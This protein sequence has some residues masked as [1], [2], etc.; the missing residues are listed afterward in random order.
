MTVEEAAEAFELSHPGSSN[1]LMECPACLC[2]LAS[3]DPSRLQS[4]DLIREL[5]ALD[6]NVK[7]EFFKKSRSVIAAHAFWNSFE[8]LTS[9][10]VKRDNL[11]HRARPETKL[12]NIDDPVIFAA[13]LQ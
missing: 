6:V 10:Y 5:I 11:E 12:K 1:E 8:A 2:L 3:K 7:E 9:R 13:L 4:G